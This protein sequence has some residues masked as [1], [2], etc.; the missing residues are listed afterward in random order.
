MYSV[1][2]YLSSDQEPEKSA[3]PGGTRPHL[4]V[5]LSRQ[6]STLRNSGDKHRAA[7]TAQTV[8]NF[9]ASNSTG[10]VQKA[11]D[12]LLIRQQGSVISLLAELL[13]AESYELATL[14]LVNR[15]HDQIRCERV[16][17]AMSSAW[18]E[19]I[20][21]PLELKAVSQQATI[22]K[23]SVDSLLVTAA[24]QEAADRQCAVSWPN[25]NKS[26]GIL[27][28]HRILASG[29]SNIC[30]RSV[31][32]YHQEKL[33]GAIL[34]EL[35]DETTWS[36]LVLELLDQL[37][38]VSAPV[39]ITRLENNWPLRKRINL[40][41]GYFARSVFGSQHVGI[42]SL[43]LAGVA[44]LL[45]TCVWPTNLQV[46]ASAEVNPTE[47]RILVAPFDGFIDTV[48]VRAGD[49]VVEGQALLRFDT[50]E[51]EL[52]ITKK[53]N[54][55]QI[56]NADFR[57]AMAEH[58]RKAMAITQA[59]LSRA[60]AE[61]GLLLQQQSRAEL[62]APDNGIVLSD[63]L[64]HAIGAPVTRGATLLQLAPQT[65]H[66]V[67]LLVDEAYIGLITPGRQ[68]ALTLRSAPGETIAFKVRAIHPIAEASSG[69]TR[70][71]VT[72]DLDS[73]EGGQSQTI[74]TVDNKTDVIAKLRPG[75]T[76][77]AR[78]DAGRTI[79]IDRL[80]RDLVNWARQRWWALFG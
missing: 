57:V 23:S 73:L 32:M 54:D 17:L 24:L 51:L 68:G 39:L 44:A 40:R 53:Y 41:L 63:A 31:P 22:D 49:L 65:G 69:S 72:A 80:T 61:H 77:I 21:Q 26:L 8:A 46:V 11:Q 30:L 1:H 19:A 25:S 3:G 9:T 66:E 43:M 71:R 29:R 52:Q 48:L 33:V 37:A 12:Q 27:A 75:Q 20:D 70:F 6:K 42:K 18:D 47:R 10:K 36:D 5:K 35:H 55:I 58:D 4:P 59:A 38:A 76:G 15:L 34:L 2:D 13:D 64:D 16:A 45:I 56:A 50:R 78:I 28:A 74:A 60:R 14:S 62:R 67:H 7:N 79:L